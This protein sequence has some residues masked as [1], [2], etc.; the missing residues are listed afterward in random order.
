[1]EPPSSSFETTRST[2][3]I[4]SRHE[5][6]HSKTVRIQPRRSYLEGQAVRIRQLR[7]NAAAPRVG[8]AR[9]LSAQ[10]E[11]NGDFTADPPIYDPLTY[12]PGL[13]RQPLPAISFRQIGSTGVSEFFPIYTRSQQ[14]TGAGSESGRN[15][16][17]EDQRQPGNGTGRLAHFS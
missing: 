13:V 5:R 7:R 8:A 4:S 10:E 15:P 14:P 11:L 17:S 16:G 1:M 3:G 6:N 12:D 9:P 2:P